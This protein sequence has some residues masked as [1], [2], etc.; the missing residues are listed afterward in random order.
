MPATRSAAR[1]Y[2]LRLRY[3]YGS[4][5]L[6]VGGWLGYTH[7]TV[8][9]PVTHAL[10]RLFYRSH[11]LRVVHVAAV[12]VIY[13]V[14][15]VRCA[16][17]YAFTAFTAW[18]LRCGCGCIHTRSRFG[19]LLPRCTV[20][21]SPH[22][23]F[24]YRVYGSHRVAFTCLTH[25]YVVCYTTRLRFFGYGSAFTVG[26]RTRLR[27]YGSAIRLH[28]LIPTTTLRSQC[29][30]CHLL[31][32]R[33]VLPAVTVLRCICG[34]FAVWFRTYAPVTPLRFTV[35]TPLRHRITTGYTYRLLPRLRA[36]YVAARYRLLWL[37]RAVLYRVVLRLVLCGCYYVCGYCVR[38]LH[39]VRT[40]YLYDIYGTF[41]HTRGYLTRFVLFFSPTRLPQL[42]TGYGLYG[43]LRFP[44]SAVV[45][46]QLVTTH[47]LLLVAV[48]LPTVATLACRVA[49]V[50]HGYALFSPD[51]RFCLQ[52][53]TATYLHRLYYATGLRFFGYRIHRLRVHCLWFDTTLR[54]TVT[55]DTVY[56][57]FTFCCCTLPF[58]YV[59]FCRVLP[60]TV[61]HTHTWILYI[62]GYLLPHGSLRSRLLRCGLQF[63]RLPGYAL[64]PHHTRLPCIYRVGFCL[65]FSVLPLPTFTVLRSHIAL[66]YLCVIHGWF[67][68]LRSYRYRLLR[69]RYTQFTAVHLTVLTVRFCTYT[70]VAARTART[71]R[72]PDTPTFTVYTVAYAFGYAAVAVA[73]TLPLVRTF[74]RLRTLPLRF[75][76]YGY[77]L[78][79]PAAHACLPATL[80]LRLYGSTPLRAFT[81]CHYAFSYRV[82]V[83]VCYTFTLPR[84]ARFTVHLRG[85]LVTVCGYTRLHC[86]TH[87]DL[88]VLIPIL[89]VLFYD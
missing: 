80:R 24:G 69:F 53:P 57:V 58:T 39:C 31:R 60:V 16:D 30:C 79:T 61:T 18:L 15:A 14:Y 77:G 10:P 64:P 59:W 3:L 78:H 12:L 36:M 47:L 5:V 20:T 71:A 13:H 74:A 4:C 2:T 11:G 83:L 9:H 49:T 54:L 48:G 26:L 21:R 17:A 82:P 46:T 41:Y 7:R 25:L 62:T 44:S 66:D 75:A 6:P 42:F 76:G 28:C 1:V 50:L 27:R 34:W 8:P 19:L 45:T 65:Q 40:D 43:Y 70:F 89:F 52:L 88:F 56:T 81:F 35:T 67:H 55:H 51:T 63:C 37:P 87:A 86:R 73:F 33:L 22:V 23:P 32:S 38:L 29:G 84:S 85:W 68:G 72:L